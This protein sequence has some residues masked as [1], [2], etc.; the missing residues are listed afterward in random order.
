MLIYLDSS[1]LAKL[2]HLATQQ[3]DAAEK[4]LQWW[5]RAGCELGLS[6]HHAQE[7]AQLA[8]AESIKRRLLVVEM[9]PIIRCRY[10]LSLSVLEYEIQTQLIG[11]SLNKE[12]QYSVL[13]TDFFPLSTIKDFKQVVVDTEERFKLMRQRLSAGAEMENISKR[14]MAEGKEAMRQAEVSWNSR[15]ANMH[16]RE[17]RETAKTFMQ[18]GLQAGG[19]QLHGASEQL[20]DN[21]FDLIEQGYSDRDA[22]E[23]VYGIREYPITKS[24]P[25]QD[26][27]D[28]YLFFLLA[29]EQARS[30]SR[31]LRQASEKLEAFVPLLDPYKCPG[32]RL[33]LAISRARK[34]AP[35]PAEPGDEVDSDHVMFA[36]YV[37]LAFVDKRTFEFIKQE[38]RRNT[39]VLP[40]DANGR[41]RLA[42]TL[43]KVREEI[44]KELRSGR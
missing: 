33:K 13:R 18:R 2:E 6:V 38:A 22:W 5:A 23:S 35:K 17:A 31:Y 43:Q 42:P 19:E 29:R 4:F 32:F 27:N 34:R 16:P 24:V 40:P 44:E 8:D 26:L 39:P 14:D 41:L 12:P 36:P 15:F 9:F 3:P 21:Y 28:V 11:L 1:H 25:D 10:F 30:V 20:V 7:I 37:D